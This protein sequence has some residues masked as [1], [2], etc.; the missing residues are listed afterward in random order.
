MSLISTKCS[1]E[2]SEKLTE[3]IM[4]IELSTIPLFYLAVNLGLVFDEVSSDM[5]MHQFLLMYVIYFFSIALLS[6]SYLPQL[7]IRC[8]C[9]CVFSAGIMAHRNKMGDVQQT[10]ANGIFTFLIIVSQELA[11]LYVN[12]KAKAKLFIQN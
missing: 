12:S 7:I 4:P 2:V 11:P 9:I 5:R 6:V 1:K 10:G 3:L 8:V